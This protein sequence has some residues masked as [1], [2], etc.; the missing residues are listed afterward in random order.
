MNVQVHD[1]AQVFIS[2]SSKGRGTRPTYVGTVER[3]LN[4]KLSLP[5]YQCRSKINLYILVY[6]CLFYV[7]FLFVRRKIFRRV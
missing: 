5:E 1:R 2:C 6:T 7:L 4:K 3:W